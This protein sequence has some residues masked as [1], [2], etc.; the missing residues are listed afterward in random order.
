LPVRTPRWRLVVSPQWET[1]A[2]GVG[3]E[4]GDCPRWWRISF[5][6]CPKRGRRRVVG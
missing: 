3:A 1:A 2:P 4:E 6:G 5:A